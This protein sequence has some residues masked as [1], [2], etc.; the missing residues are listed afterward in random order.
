MSERALHSNCVTQ[1]KGIQMLRED[2]TLREL[3]VLIGKVHLHDKVEITN[4][5]VRA[6][7]SVRAHG[8]LAVHHSTHKHVVTNG[9]SE[10]MILRLQSES[11][12]TSVPVDHILLHERKIDSL[13]RVKSDELGR[14]HY[15]LLLGSFV[16]V[17]LSLIQLSDVVV[18]QHFLRLGRVDSIKFVGRV[19]PRIH[20]DTGATSRVV[21]QER[22]TVIY[23]IMHNNPRGIV[24][25]MFSDFGPF[26]VLFRRIFYFRF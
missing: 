8:Q 19:R 25:V 2:A 12:P 22:C 5:I 11:E 1:L 21:F 13:L 9:Q 23:L 6:G 20:C 4:L 10:N 3:R 14:F 15:F 17:V 16:H 18:R 26:E 24:V 7:G